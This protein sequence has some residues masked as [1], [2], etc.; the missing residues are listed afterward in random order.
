ML[1]L[2]SKFSISK[3]GQHG[4]KFSGNHCCKILKNWNLFYDC[5]LIELKSFGECLRC[6][7]LVVS[8]CFGSCLQFDNENSIG[9]FSK[10]YTSL[11]EDFHI[12]LTPKVHTKME[13]IVQFYRE[14]NLS[15]EFIVNK[16][17]KVFT[18]TL[19]THPG[20]DLKSL[21]IV[22]NMALAYNKLLLHTMG[23]ILTNRNIMDPKH[24]NAGIMNK[25]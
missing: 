18:M 24:I 16:V 17:V 21:A 23:N 25:H 2:Q 4:G 11:M 22:Q 20:L 7:G 8:S 14:K 13:H 12:S 19:S 3:T 5:L 9:S 15:W 6:L 10:V 1:S